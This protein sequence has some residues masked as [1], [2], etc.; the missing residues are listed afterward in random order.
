MTFLTTVPEGFVGRV[1]AGPVGS[2][3]LAVSDGARFVLIP[4][5]PKALALQGRTVDVARDPQGR[6]VGLRARS[7]D[8]G[9]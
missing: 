2:G 7:L 4:T 6:F 9:R 3:Y 1:H 8:R 5:T